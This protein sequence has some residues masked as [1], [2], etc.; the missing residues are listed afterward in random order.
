MNVKQNHL[1]K[2]AVCG[3]FIACALSWL[4]AAG[5][6]EQLPE[7]ILRLHILANSDSE[8]DQALKLKVRDAVLT[9]AARWCRGAGSLYEANAAV[10]THLEGI[11]QAAGD[12][13]KENGFTDAVTVTVTDEFFHTR[14]YE[15]FT[16]P[17][18]RYRTLRV[19]IGEGS[20]HNWWCVVFPALCLPA[21][22]GEDVLAELP[23]EQREAVRDKGLQ[24][25][26]KLVELYEELKN[27]LAPGA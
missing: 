16:L 22:Q 15:D 11:A 21:A 12:V 7:N 9:E 17:A 8:A 25:S 20:G 3:L 13:V 27:W 14:K 18:G 4:A 24:V 2:A 19:V 26:F 23:P 6:A 10:C 1:F 5:P